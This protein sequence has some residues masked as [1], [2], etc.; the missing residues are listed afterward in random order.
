MVAKRVSDLTL[1]ELRELIRQEF[2]ELSQS[3]TDNELD[4]SLLD[5]D[6]SDFPVDDLGPW[7]EN[8]EIRRSIEQPQS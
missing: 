1:D 4:N 8:L 6:L 3:S 7:P 2:V 5:S